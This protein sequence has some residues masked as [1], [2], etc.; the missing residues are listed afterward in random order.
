MVNV[1]EIGEKLK[2]MLEKFGL[3]PLSRIV[4][5]KSKEI[6]IIYPVTGKNELSIENIREIEKYFKDELKMNGSGLSKKKNLKNGVIILEFYYTVTFRSD[7]FLTYFDGHFFL[8]FIEIENEKDIEEILYAKAQ[9][10]LE[11]LK[12]YV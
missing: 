6:F 7:I 2:E 12:F 4:K 10:D 5:T 8:N 1:E 11:E 9:R 3:E